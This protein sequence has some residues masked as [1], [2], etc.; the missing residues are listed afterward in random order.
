MNEVAADGLIGVLIFY[1]V[2]VWVLAIAAGM[3]LSRAIKDTACKAKKLR[4]RITN[5]YNIINSKDCSMK[6]E[7]DGKADVRRCKKG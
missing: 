5:H 6:I 1:I 7:K 4:D 3:A 2:A